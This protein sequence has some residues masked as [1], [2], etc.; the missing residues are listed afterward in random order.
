MASAS[1][2]RDAA[3]AGAKKTRRQRFS[4]Y[5]GNTAGAPMKY[6]PNAN[7]GHRMTSGTQAE[8]LEHVAACADCGAAL[9]ATP[10]AMVQLPPSTLAQGDSTEP[11][12]GPDD[13]RQR[14]ARSDVRTGV[15]GI[16]AGLA[17]TAGTMVFPTE[18]GTYLF[19]WGPIAYGVYRLARG[20]GH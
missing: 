9:V 17:I 13:L 16:L 7:C 8:Y 6:C 12:E 11:E 5:S 18:Q 19:A 1:P 4:D 20:L 14:R 15:F 2:A 3:C 10:G